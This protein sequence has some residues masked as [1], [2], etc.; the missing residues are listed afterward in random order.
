MRQRLLA[1]VGAVLAIA[2]A[3]WTPANAQ[4]AASYPNQPVKII[5]PFAPG[6]A[7]DF[8]ARCAPHLP[9]NSYA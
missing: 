1:L 2:G 4:D 6:G 8:A 5:V 9:M 7:S 3:Q